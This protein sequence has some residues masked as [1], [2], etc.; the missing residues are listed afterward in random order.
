M[1]LLNSSK[2][3]SKF[4]DCVQTTAS[5]KKSARTKAVITVN[6]GGISTLKISSGRCFNP[7]TLGTICILGIRINPPIIENSAAPTDEK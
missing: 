7:S 5:P 3:F 4:V 2:S 1:I 6:G